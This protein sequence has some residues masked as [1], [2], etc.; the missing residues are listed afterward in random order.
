M[1]FARW[2]NI[3][4]LKCGYDDFYRRQHRKERLMKYYIAP[5]E[6]ITTVQY[7]TTYNKFYGGADKYFAPFISNSK[8]AAKEIYGLKPENN[9][10][11]HLV[12]Q[13]LTNN[14]ETFIKAAYELKKLGYEEINLNL[15]C[16]SGTV[17][18]KGRGAG[19]L[20]YPDKLDDFLNTIYEMCD[21]QISIKTRIGMRSKEEWD[22]ILEIYAKYPISELII[23]PRLQKDGYGLNIYLDAYEKAKDRLNC[24]LCYNGDIFSFESHKEKTGKLKESR[25]V[26]LGRGIIANPELLENI[27]KG[28]V[29]EKIED[30]SRLSEFLEE[31]LFKYIDV[32]DGEKP[33]LFKMKDIWNFLG[34]SFEEKEAELKKIKKSKSIA[35]YKI[36]VNNLLK[37]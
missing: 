32:M 8:L 18:S 13:I 6:G 16:P 19:F 26:M 21:M 29:V 9:P 20:A 35:E 15:G 11:I 23:H 30:I 22:H 17:V 33:V 36:A 37:D 5:M 25:A 14:S 24:P 2:N 27:K 12:P 4:R 7:R 28:K 31:L 34:K 3:R 10:G 1:D